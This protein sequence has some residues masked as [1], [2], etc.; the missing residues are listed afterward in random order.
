MKNGFAGV[1]SERG[2]I[3]P[4]SAKS[5]VGDSCSLRRLPTARRMVSFAGLA[6]PQSVNGWIGAHAYQFRPCR[7]LTPFQRADRES[8]LFSKE[9]GSLGRFD[10]LWH[11]YSDCRNLIDWNRV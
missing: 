10:A 6:E 3:L 5:S 7:G 11:E 1:P 4:K 9:N 8:V 2:L